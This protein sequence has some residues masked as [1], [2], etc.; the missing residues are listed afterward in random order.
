MKKLSILL[1]IVA[2]FVLAVGNTNA[3]NSKEV[4][5]SETEYWEGEDICTD[6][7]LKGYDTYTVTVWDKNDGNNP[8]SKYQVRIKG[9]YIGY[10][11]GKSY[12]WSFVQNIKYNEAISAAVSN[13]VDNAVLKCEGEPIGMYKLRAHFTMNSNGEIIVWRVEE[14][15]YQCF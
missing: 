6:D 10:P 14:K 3:Q 15:D 9:E 13:R 5:Y 1:A 12:T 11:S 8:F 4:L 7:I 2:L